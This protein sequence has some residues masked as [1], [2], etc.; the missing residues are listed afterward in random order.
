MRLVFAGLLIIALASPAAAQRPAPQQSQGS[1]AAID[2]VYA[3][4][5]IADEHQRL[6]C[7]DNAVGRMHEAQNRGDLVAV[8]RQQAERVNREAFGFSLPSLGNLLAGIGSHSRTQTEDIAEISAHVT[9]VSME[10]SGRAT[11]TLDNGQQWEQ[12]DDENTRNVRSG[13]DVRI[14]RAMMGS[15]LMHVE[16]GGPAL[17]VRRVQ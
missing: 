7:Y 12:I 9:R 11:F 2:E 15:F 5:Q 14:R 17:R 8:D 3:C 16:A 4:S 13:G 1:P 10:R 6:Q